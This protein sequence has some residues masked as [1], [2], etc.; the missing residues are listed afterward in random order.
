MWSPQLEPKIL[1]TPHQYKI[2]TLV[3]NGLTNRLIA[4]YFNSTPG[5]IEQHLV[6]L[7]RRHGFKNRHDAAAHLHRMVAVDLRKERSKPNGH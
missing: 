4:E 6:K 5:A 1:V 7:F 3:K 2:V